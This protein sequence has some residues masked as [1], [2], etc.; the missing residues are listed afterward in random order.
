M[1]DGIYER[2]CIQAAKDA[3]YETKATQCPWSIPRDIEYTLKTLD[4]NAPVMGEDPVTNKKY[5]KIR[6]VDDEVGILSGESLELNLRCWPC[7]DVLI[8]ETRFRGLG[9]AGRN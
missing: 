6:I 8:R 5:P 4:K 3:F 2:E 7:H 9:Y 1:Y